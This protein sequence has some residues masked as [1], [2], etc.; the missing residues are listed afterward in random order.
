MTRYIDLS[1]STE[2]HQ[3]KLMREIW[4][5]LGYLA[6]LQS[7]LEAAKAENARLRAELEEAKEENANL[8]DKLAQAVAL[9]ETKGGGDE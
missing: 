9:I 8:K 5:P 6:Q 4:M 1:E 2:W 3:Y 7:E